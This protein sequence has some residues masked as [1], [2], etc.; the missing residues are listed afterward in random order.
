MRKRLF[1]FLLLSLIVPFALGQSVDYLP[2]D[3][4][5]FERCKQATSH[6][7][8]A[9]IG[10]HIIGTALFFLDVPYVGAT[11]EKE[12]ERL[13]VNLREMDCT[14]FVENVLALTRTF[15]L[16]EPSF[17]LFTKQLE[18]IRY[19][20]G[21][22]GDYVS[23]LHYATG[24]LLDNAKKGVLKDITPY[25]S[26]AAKL[27]LSLSFMSSHPNLYPALKNSPV[28]VQQIKQEEKKISTASFMYIP[29]ASLV[30]DSL[31]VQNGDVVFF[32]TSIAGLDVSHMGLV[33][34]AEGELRFIH[35]SQLLGKVVIQTESIHSYMKKNSKQ[36]GVI[37]ARPL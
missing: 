11:L 29:K 28:S 1:S 31:K 3:S 15:R 4:L 24:W 22:Q 9:P 37:F 36:I 10:E 2:K 25:L 35:A 20:S 13:V 33:Y 5:I 6:L 17:A 26:G 23:R 30:N 16:E 12:P 32:A 18:L 27:P 8:K 7:K 19:R 34:W 14:T 21:K